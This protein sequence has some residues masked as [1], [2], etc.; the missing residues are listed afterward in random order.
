[1]VISWARQLTEDDETGMIVPFLLY[2]V[3][4]GVPFQDVWERCRAQWHDERIL[5]DEF[6]LLWLAVMKA[7][8]AS[9]GHGRYLGSGISAENFC[10]IHFAYCGWIG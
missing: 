3:G 10:L 1:M 9:E 7:G 4:D 6:R 2:N 8:C 5:S